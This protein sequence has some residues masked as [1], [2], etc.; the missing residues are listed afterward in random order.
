MCITP[1]PTQQQAKNK[2]WSW[3]VE[4]LWT[5]LIRY[6]ISEWFGGI[7]KQTSPSAG[8]ILFLFFREKKQLPH[9]ISLGQLQQ[10]QVQCGLKA[11]DSLEQIHGKTCG[12]DLCY[13]RTQIKGANRGI[14]AECKKDC[15]VDRG[16]KA[17]SQN[18][19]SNEY[20]TG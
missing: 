6:E 14:W 7:T 17:G 8:Y 12:R 19:N 10:Q 11:E 4:K 1:S 16:G 9:I 5:L 3:H 13:I 18:S 2:S 15:T 20:V